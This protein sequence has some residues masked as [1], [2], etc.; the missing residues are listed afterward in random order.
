MRLGDN[1]PLAQIFQVMKMQ[2]LLKYFTVHL[3]RPTHAEATLTSDTKQAA[4][5]F[6]RHWR[7]FV[8]LSDMFSGCLL[9]SWYKK[10]LQ[11]RSEFSCNFVFGIFVEGQ[12]SRGVLWTIHP[13]SKP[14]SKPE[15]NRLLIINLIQL[16]WWI[17]TCLDS[18][19][20]KNADVTLKKKA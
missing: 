18:S 11:G 16:I 12:H 13:I 9:F 3:Q 17:L 20:F 7:L 5:Q 19:I 15:I 1:K 10:V 8:G 6:S 14:R 2:S 4:H